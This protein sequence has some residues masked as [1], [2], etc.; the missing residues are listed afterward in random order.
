[1][2]G[3]AEIVRLEKA[4]GPLTKRIQLDPEGRLKSDGSCCVMGRGTAWRTPIGCVS[5]LGELIGTLRS[6]EAIALGALRRDLPERVQVVTKRKLNGETSTGVIARSA[7]NIVFRP[8][9]PGFVLLDFDSKGM[10]AE[11][12]ER[13]DREGG[14]WPALL[15]V[16]PEL[17]GVARVVRASTS[18]GLYRQDTGA[19]VAGS[20]GIHVY[21]ALRDSADSGRFLETLHERC[22][23]TGLGWMMVGAGGQLLQRSV[24]DRMVGSPERLVFEGAPILVEPLAQSAQARRPVVIEG[25]LLDT[26][27]ACPPLMVAERAEFAALLAKA[28]HRLAGD[29]AKA[30]DE[31][32]DR[33]AA[34]LVK[35]SGMSRLAAIATIRCQ[36]N[37]ILL[38]D[39]ELPFDD[40]D[41]AG[42][43]VTDIL[44]DPA[45]FE[46]E[47]LADPLEGVEYGPCKA[48]IMRREDGTPWIHSFAHG[49]T[50]YELKFDAEA[51]KAAMAKVDAGDV[52]TVLTEMLIRAEVDPVE[53][54]ALIGFAKER[55]GIGVRSI[56]RQIKE[57]R[58]TRQE[59]Q[60][61]AD[62][63]R[64]LAE[65]GDPRPLLPVPGAL[66]EYLPVMDTLNSVLAQSR[67]RIPPARNM[68][69]ALVCVR[70]V[71]IPA[72]MRS[73]APTKAATSP[74][75]RLNSGP[76]M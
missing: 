12:A 58:Q 45:A 9:Q 39:V 27:A 23:L 25:E 66:G 75:R 16:M 5:Q 53:Q 69:G 10:P 35:R 11:V 21:L 37:G 73:S 63:D 74:P 33:Q 26:R 49:R 6:A 44:A 1:M 13:L 14:F 50:V 72:P 8:G 61:E 65:R 68:E 36:C 29:S 31:F 54:E 59:E 4:G 41:L 48:R 70:L 60:A 55:T 43:T 15:K 76:S 52:V 38:P 67:D 7:E 22:W 30:R 28:K 20:N 2:V 46:G 3:T 71:R 18:A 51:I 24:V 32:I 34:D 47:T 56:T 17:T 19:L 57:A 62:R 64:R 40:P 42:K